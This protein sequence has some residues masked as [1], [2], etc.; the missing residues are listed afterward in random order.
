MNLQQSGLLSF[1]LVHAK[2]PFN[3]VGFKSIFFLNYYLYAFGFQIHLFQLFLLYVCHGEISSSL[4]F[5]H[6]WKPQ[7]WSPCIL[8]PESVRQGI[9]G[10]SEACGKGVQT[11][12]KGILK[13]FFYSN[14]TYV[15]FEVLIMFI[16]N[17]L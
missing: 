11:R 10:T 13:Q 8:V 14:V 16:W 17:K 6:R 15:T 5:N 3:D 9:M 12:G 7:K 2:T 4:F 1:N